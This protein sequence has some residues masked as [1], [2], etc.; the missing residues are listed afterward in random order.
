MYCVPFDPK[1]KL[2]IVDT[3]DPVKNIGIK[4][5]S[6]LAKEMNY[7]TTFGMNVLTIVL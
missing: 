5:V 2:K 7:Q 6:K 3:E 4:L 1:S